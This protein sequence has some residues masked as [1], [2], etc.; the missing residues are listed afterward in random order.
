MMLADMLIENGE[1]IDGPYCGIKEALMAARRNN[2][3]AGIL[4]VNLKGN[5]VYPVA[6]ILIERK[7][8]FIFVTG[9]TAEAIDARY[10]HIPVLQKPIEPQHIWAALQGS[11]S[12]AEEEVPVHV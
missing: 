2:L 7:I 4:D 8:P 5:A 10:N 9:Y 3:K 6:D 1:L 11:S 12:N